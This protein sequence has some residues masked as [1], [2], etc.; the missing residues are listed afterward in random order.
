MCQD[1][2]SLEINNE[3]SEYIK[4]SSKKQFEDKI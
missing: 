2:G 3:P 4:Y 1:T